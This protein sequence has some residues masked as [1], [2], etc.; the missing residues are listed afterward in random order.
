[1]ERYSTG[2]VVS[3][4][5]TI[6]GYRQVGHGPAV[7]LLHGAME[8][9]QSHMQVAQALAD[10]FTIYLPDRRGR[11]LSGPYRE[12]HSIETDVQ[13]MAAL[14]AKTGAHDV[15]GVSSGAIIWLQAAL[16]LPGIRKAV[17]FEPPLPINGSLPTA[18]MHRY[19]T[20][21][22]QGEVAAALVSAMKG[23]LMGPPIFNVIPR[24]LL[25]RLTTAMMA[26]EEKKAG[27]QFQLATEMHGA[28]ERFKGIRAEV[29]LLGG[30]KSP[31]YLKAGLDALEKVLP[32]VTRVE[33]PG[34]GHGA[35]GNSDRGGRPERAAQVLRQFFG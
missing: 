29:L 15:M 24:T 32:H 23:T 8:S 20:E 34:L 7:I 9:A 16:T 12:D 35:T 25:E 21:I 30:S 11:G 17:I 10:R 27:S 1:M 3:K 18:F 28:L 14:L 33:L 31:A 19:D 22:E 4:D 26:S 5:G 2:S 6:I 13:D